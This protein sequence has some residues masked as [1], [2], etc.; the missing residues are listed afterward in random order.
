MFLGR[1]RESQTLRKVLTRSRAALAI[2]Y[3]RRRVGKSTLLRHA[4][5]GAPHIYYQATRVADADS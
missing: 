1:R 2:I 3:G 4:V 5:H